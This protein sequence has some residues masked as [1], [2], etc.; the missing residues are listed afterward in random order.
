M[1]S[2]TMYFDAEGPEN[3]EAALRAARTRA[4]EL[5]I[6]RVLVASTSG[7]TAVAALEILEGLDIIAVSHQAGFKDAGKNELI[8][9]NRAAI[10][11]AGVP[12]LTATHIFAGVGRAVR[13]KFE[14][15]TIG[16]I[17]ASTLRV[18]GQ[19]AKVGCEIAMM[20]ADAGLVPTD[21]DVI[22]IAGTG[23]GADTAI[24]LR[25]VHSHDFFSLKVRE[26]ICKPRF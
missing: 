18:F 10:A 12:V 17:M 11:A 4:G 25:P 14:T 20:A 1:E 7:A 21:A 2:R 13:L 26:I 22:T 3:T 19:G 5:D 6:K 23:R 9:A 15:Y 16:E 8:E 24:V